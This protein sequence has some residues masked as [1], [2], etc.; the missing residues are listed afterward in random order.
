M[1]TFNYPEATPVDIATLLPI[2]GENPE[3][4]I[5]D[6]DGNV[7]C[8]TENG[9]ILKIVQDAASHGA[10]AKSSVSVIANTG[11]RPLGLDWLP[12][13]RLLVC[14]TQRG[15]LA[16]NTQTA[17]IELL[18]DSVQ[19]KKFRIC[20]NPCVSSEGDIYFSDSSQRYTLAD[21]HRDIIDK[22][23][24]GRLLKRHASGRIEVL[25]EGLHF[26]N[27]VVLAEDESFVLVAE[28]G[29]RCIRKYWLTGALK[30]RSEMFAQDMPGMPDNMSLGSDGL[31]WVALPSATD[32]RLE[33]VHRFPYTLRA[34]L[35]RIPA[36]LQPQEKKAALVMAFDHAGNCVHFIESNPLKYGLVTGV[37]QYKDQLYMGS[38]KAKGIAVITLPQ[39]SSAL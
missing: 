15:L 19:S 7:Y 28:T 38:I 33:L 3:D 30:G 35:G 21:I 20:N 8:G 6:S 16:V 14:D 37:R 31:F 32:A 9:D 22:L 11:G 25:M 24:T 17:A 34:L 36:Q 5:L 26:A 10:A 27:G 13:G 39:T 29:A 2:C 1:T 12:D 18:A 23:P 4:V